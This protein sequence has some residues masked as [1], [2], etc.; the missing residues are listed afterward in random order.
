MRTYYRGPDA[1]VTDERFVWHTAAPRIF[2][3]RDLH[4]VGLVRAD[5]PNP[6]S[7]AAL[8][9]AT[10][11]AAAAAAGWVVAGSAL[12]AALGAMAIVTFTVAVIARKLR[13]VHMW[14][15]RA[16]HRGV[17]TIIYQSTDVRVFNQVARALRRA[18]EDER[19]A[20][21]G[22]DLVIA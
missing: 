8:L 16:S 13:T 9:A 1:L 12:S 11:L 14:Q 18:I 22:R 17:M 2:A 20:P 6:S 10:G 5:V 15:L 4:R 21:T 7:G 19:P 3:V